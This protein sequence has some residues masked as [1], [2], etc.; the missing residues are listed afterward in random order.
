MFTQGV[1][2][3]DVG[4]LVECGSH[5]YSGMLISAPVIGLFIKTFN[6]LPN[7]HTDELL[8]YL[9]QPNHAMPR[10]AFFTVGLGYL[11]LQTVLPIDLIP[12]VWLKNIIVKCS[13]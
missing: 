2:V 6:I 10:C 5:N 4:W 8:E 13:K 12:V 1:D 11:H 9:V 7:Y 3:C